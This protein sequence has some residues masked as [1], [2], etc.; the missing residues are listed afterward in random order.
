[1]K[2]LCL[3][4]GLGFATRG[5]R[6]EKPLGR[7]ITN[8]ICTLALARGLPAPIALQFEY[9]LAE[10]GVENEHIALASEFGMAMVPR[11]PLG[12]GFFSGKY[13][14][15]D[16]ANVAGNRPPEL[17]DG[18]SE[19]TTDALLQVADETGTPPGSPLPGFQR[20]RL[21]DRF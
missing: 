21:S 5:A 15:D 16:P 13:R 2:T 11:S 1:M 3:V 18:K 12:G 17:P 20:G 8:T 7:C 19:E 14:R 6:L 9:S 10:R 4:F